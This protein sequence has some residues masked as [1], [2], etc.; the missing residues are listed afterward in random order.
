MKGCMREHGARKR[1]T[2]IAGGAAAAARGEDEKQPRKR[3]GGTLPRSVRV[4]SIDNR[5]V[6]QPS[7]VKR[8]RA[9]PRDRALSALSPRCRLLS[10]DKSFDIH[11]IA[12]GWCGGRCSRCAHA[13]AWLQGRASGRESGRASAHPIQEESRRHEAG[14]V[15][16]LLHRPEIGADGGRHSCA[17]ADANARRRR[18]V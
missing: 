16:E 13:R 9:I 15:D 5:Q 2:Q 6:G 17:R 4:Q 18:A 7:G 1:R 11:I 10:S 12:Q 8:P 14:E 3:R